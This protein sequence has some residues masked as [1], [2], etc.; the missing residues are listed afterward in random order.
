MQI[1]NMTHFEDVLDT[2]EINPNNKATHCII[3]LHGLGADGHDF[4]PIAAQLK[5]KPELNVR[6]VFPH[7][8]VRPI[9]LN[10]G[11]QMRGWYDLKSLE[12]DRAEQDPE[13]VLISAKQVQALIDKEIEG[14]IPAS[15][16]ILAGFSQGSA[17]AL[18]A[19]LT[20][21][22]KLGGIIA[23]SGYLPILPENAHLLDK[24]LQ[25]LP[26]FMAHGK[27]DDVVQL[28][29]AEDSK[30][31]LLTSGF[32]PVWRVY[33]VA[34]GLAEQEIDDLSTWLNNTL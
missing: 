23:L 9:S 29:Y 24:S 8:P 6:Y 12:L 15:S 1:D 13:G 16:I 5:L 17:I 31:L 25:A 18:F 4:E 28:N 27:F 21:G 2:V 10:N 7:A 20:H 32:S 30:N 33:D 11:M 3:W 34:H 26:I 14:G 22:I 19:G